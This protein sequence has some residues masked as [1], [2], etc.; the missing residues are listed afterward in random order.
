MEENDLALVSREQKSGEKTRRHRLRLLNTNT[1]G[2]AEVV[3]WDVEMLAGTVTVSGSPEIFPS[4]FC[5]KMYGTNPSC[6][7]WEGGFNW[8]PFRWSKSHSFYSTTKLL[9]WV[10]PQLEMIHRDIQGELMWTLT[11]DFFEDS[12]MIHENYIHDK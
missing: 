4:L 11:K 6:G 10:V 3:A 5:E 2:M 7:V 8:G 9:D 12:N 1:E